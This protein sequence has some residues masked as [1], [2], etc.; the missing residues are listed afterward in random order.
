LFADVFDRLTGA[1]LKFV[2]EHVVQDISD[3]IGYTHQSELLHRTI[4]AD[5]KRYLQKNPDLA[6]Y[7]L[8]IRESGR[9]LFLLTNSPLY[10]VDAGMQYLV[11]A[12]VKEAGLESWTSLF[13]VVVTQANKPAFYHRQQRFRKVN[14][15][16]SLSLQAV[17]NF[18]R[19]Q[20]YT[21][22]GLEEFHRLTGYRESNVIYMGDQIYSDLVEPQKATQWKT[23]AIIKELA[24]EVEEMNCESFR[25]D[26]ARL[27][28]VERLIDEG[29]ILYNAHDAIDW[30]KTERTQLRA[31]L[32]HRVNPYFG[33]AFRTS[34]SRTAFFYNVGRYA[35]IYTSSIN[36]FLE[37]PLEYCFY[38]QR[39]FF[40]HETR[41][42]NPEYLMLELNKSAA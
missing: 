42:D 40:P 26:L 37:Y 24:H 31:R 34:T 23:A 39:S 33:S 5:P 35:D 29:Q 30:L 20:V 27:L 3:S 22:G 18:E 38:A 4:A 7:L 41:M 6:R 13:D 32:K 16:G 15:D 2:P 36:N 9:S 21:G 11:G 8:R 12:A 28:F 14:P 10:F 19:G 17:E 25:E 1:D